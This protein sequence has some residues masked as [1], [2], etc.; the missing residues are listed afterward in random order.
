MD[1]WRHLHPSTRAFSW[2]RPNDFWASR[3]DLIEFPFSWV[4]QVSSSE[5]VPCSFS[6]HS[7]VLMKVVLPE[8]FPRG[9]GRW[10]LNIS[11]LNEG[12]FAASLRDFWLPGALREALFLP[13]K[14]G[15]M[16]IKSVLSVSP[17]IILQETT[18]HLFENL[19]FYTKK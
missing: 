1:V 11:V 15:G 8:P 7:A 10:K 19:M 12:D 9:P 14:S 13:F 16:L 5:I 2:P 6:D 18:I 3:M 4:H 17:F